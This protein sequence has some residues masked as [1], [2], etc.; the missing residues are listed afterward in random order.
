MQFTRSPSWRYAR[1]ARRTADVPG[2]I[3]CLRLSC[4]LCGDAADGAL[5]DT[6]ITRLASA[7]GPTGAVVLDLSATAAVD[8]RGRAALQSLQRRLAELAIRLRLVVQEPSAFA[9][10]ES[11]GTGIELDS[12]HITV[13]T[14]VLAA[15][16]DLPGP[17]AVTPALRTLLTQ[18]PEPLSLAATGVRP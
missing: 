10:L 3:I 15:H 12:L 11:D 9:T 18:P 14:A 7:A 8:D 17:A 5:T 2:G 6:V 13:R 1:A 16:A 4:E